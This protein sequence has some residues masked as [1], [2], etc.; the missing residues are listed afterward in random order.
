MDMESGRLIYS[1]F[2]CQPEIASNPMSIDAKPF[3]PP[4]RTLM[5]PGPSDV[6]PRVLEALS[7]PTI[8]HLDPRFVEMMDQVKALLQYA[9]MT[10]N[11]LTMPVS[12]P[13]SAGME[14]CF[15]NLVEPGDKVIV[16]I[17]G[18]F[19]GR[20]KE[21][22]VR[23]GGEAVVVEDEWGRVVDPE[24]VEAALKAHPDAK[25]LAFVHAETS[26]GAQSDA[27]AL[28]RL[29]REH[30]CLT[31]VD[32]VTS[33]GGTP[34]KVDEWGAD[35]VYSGTQK[36]LSCVPGLSP[37]TFSER[38]QEAVKGR[39]HPV[40][41]WFLD[42]NLVLGYWGSGAQ[43]TYHHTAPVNSLYALHEALLILH[44]EGLERAWARHERNH[45]AL[46]AGLE[47]MG[48]GF[49]VKE[50]DRLPQLNAVTVP[51]GV[52]EAAVR[53][54]LL[55]AFSLEIGAGLGALAG[56]VWRIGLMGHASNRRNVL[57]CLAALESVLG[58]MGAPIEKGVALDAAMAVYG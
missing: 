21:N 26:T 7:R 1:R 18:V 13:G 30:G 35:A 14:T 2:H 4:V 3:L 5:G 19:G 6:P 27:A 29:A 11:A 28:C 17:N 36:C 15:A 34:V 48:I 40:Q 54:A 31:I 52:D 38:A 23:C 41:S 43:R 20:M 9:F 57:F 51:E 49:V 22:V 44:E 45:Q 55:E 10:E 16:C 46:K 58:G 53:R 25:I 39:R 32:T 24:K 47:A 56:K 33:L 50:G 37:I 42:L 12:A 8:G